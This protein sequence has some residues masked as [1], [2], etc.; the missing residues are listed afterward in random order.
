MKTN[1][2]V[3]NLTMTVSL[4]LIGLLIHVQWLAASD[5]L[6]RLHD[7]VEMSSV[8]P[9]VRSA[10]PEPIDA[11]KY[12]NVARRY[13]FS[14]DRSPKRIADPP[15]PEVLKLMPE[16]PIVFGVMGLP[17]GTAVFMA[18]RV[19]APGTTFRLEDTCGGFKIVA[20]DSESITFEWSGKQ[21]TRNIKDLMD[22]SGGQILSERQKAI[23][24]QTQLH[25]VDNRPI[26]AVPSNLTLKDLGD[27]I[28]TT[29]RSCKQGETS[30]DGAMVVDGYRKSSVSTP[31]GPLCRW[32]K[33]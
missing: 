18:D 22:P 30:A 4:C 8:P 3:W 20:L 24:P 12:V 9:L 13:I 32:R 25:T 19:G 27:E 31:F 17:S 23:P 33:G 2:I 28:T 10:P 15:A 11:A 1:F 6:A 29:M 26:Q 14:Q 7:P 21:I 5:R 16:L